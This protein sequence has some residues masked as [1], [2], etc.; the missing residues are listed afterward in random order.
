MAAFLVSEEIS[1]NQVFHLDLNF[2]Y[3]CNLKC[4]MCSGFRSTKWREDE[5]ALIKHISFREPINEYL[6]AEKYS[7]E[8][9]ILLVDK[10][11]NLKRLDF[12]GG[13]PSI[14]KN[15]WKFLSH[16]I[17]TGR[18]SDIHVAMTTNGIEVPDEVALL[19]KF[20]STSICFSLE[21]TDK[22]YR[23]IRGQKHG[24][25]RLEENLLLYDSIGNLSFSFNYTLQAYNVFEIIPTLKW[26]IGQ[27]K[28]LK[29]FDVSQIRFDQCILSEPRYLKVTVLPIS[30]R[31]EAADLILSS[32][33]Y[34]E[35]KVIL[36]PI[37]EFF[38]DFN[39]SD[40][41]YLSQFVSFTEALDKIRDQ[42]INHFI[43]QFAKLFGGD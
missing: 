24:I 37:I 20:K 1:F 19:S 35:Y 28:T 34:S 43:P 27:S 40:E 3:L 14:D 30:I 25:S 39:Q 2:S 23:Y 16:L 10:C 31:Q 32:E 6:Y 29:S 22:A 7:V 21:G 42:K 9:Y 12:K 18:A 8:D 26:F 13:E 17:K 4:R 36:D 11:H 38:L 5:N 41:A 33:L 15:V